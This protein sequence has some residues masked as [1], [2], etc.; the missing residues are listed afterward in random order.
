MEHSLT[1]KVMYGS[2]SVPGVYFKMLKPF[3]NVK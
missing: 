2:V 3:V 1:D